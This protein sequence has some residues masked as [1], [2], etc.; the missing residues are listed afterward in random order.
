MGGVNAARDNQ[1]MIQKQIRILE[2]RLDKAL[3]KFNEALANNKSLREQIDNL[4]QERVSSCCCWWCCQ[5]SVVVV[6]VINDN[7]LITPFQVVFDNIYMKLEKEL[8][9]KKKQMANIIEMSNLAYEQRD[10]AQL[11]IAAIEQQN[12]REAGEFDEQMQD[13]HRIIEED[14][15][16]VAE[17]ANNGGGAL[18]NMSVD[19]EAVSVCVIDDDDVVVAMT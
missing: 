5:Q 6:Y 14:K 15:K 13:L 7:V 18:G 1:R 12:R 2:N 8:V 10:G 4:R 17:M 19:A 16:R 3:I 9:E 11:E